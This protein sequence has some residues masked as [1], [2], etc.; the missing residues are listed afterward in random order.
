MSSFPRRRKSATRD[1]PA[2]CGTKGEEEEEEEFEKSINKRLFKE[3]CEEP[4]VMK[5]F[6]NGE[7]SN[8]LRLE[9]KLFRV[10]DATPSEVKKTLS[11]YQTICRILLR[12]EEGKSKDGTRIRRIDYAS[13]KIMKDN[14]RLIDTGYKRLGNVPGVEVGDEYHYRVELCLIGLHH[15]TQGGIDYMDRGDKILA[16]SIVA[17]GGYDDKMDGSNIL[18]YT[19]QGGEPGRGKKA[20]DQ[21]LKRG[22]LALK[23]SMEE[24]TPVRVIRG[25]KETKG[26]SWSEA[27]MN[28]AAALVYDGLYLVKDYWK[29]RGCHGNYVFKYK[30]ERIEGQPELAMKELKKFSKASAREGVCMYDVSQGAENMRISAVNTIDNERPPRFQYKARMEYPQRYNPAPAQGCECINGCSSFSKCPCTEKNGGKIPFNHN[31]ALVEVNSLIYECGRSCKCPHTSCY[32][33]VSQHGIKLPLEV[34]KTKNKGWGVRCLSSIPSGTFIC[35]YTGVLL[36]DIEAEK[37]TGADEYMFDIRDKYNDHSVL[38]DLSYIL[39]KLRPSSVCATVENGG[40][41]IDAAKCGNVGRFIN[42]SCSPNLCAQNVLYDHHDKRMPHIMFFAATNIPPLQ[43]L[44]YRYNYKV[45]QVFDSDG[46]IRKKNCY[47][48]SLEC[49]GSW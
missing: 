46:N 6:S 2:G 45:G 37:R 9:K 23:N 11:M 30:L 32:N 19:G 12:D 49:N 26:Q 13:W 24:G 34:F 10:G 29:E 42:H 7:G 15:Q 17:S 16:T 35:E 48:G 21:E 41:T 18:I 47:C 27:R 44:T 3:K 36:Q 22:N 38:N 39:A 25:F 20:T 4:L 40:F 5:R 43:E 8:S 1:W 33:R 28:M 14:N 31:G